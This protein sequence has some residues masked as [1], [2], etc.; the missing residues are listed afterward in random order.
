M[1]W[2]STGCHTVAG[3]PD[4]TLNSYKSGIFKDVYLYIYIYVYIYTEFLHINWYS[5]S[6][7]NHITFVF[8]IGA[9]GRSWSP[10]DA[11]CCIRLSPQFSSLDFR[12]MDPHRVFLNSVLPKYLRPRF[13][14]MDFVIQCKRLPQVMKR[15]M[16]LRLGRKGDALEG[17]KA[18][19]DP[20][21]SVP[22][23]AWDIKGR[24]LV[25]VWSDIYIKHVNCQYEWMEQK[26]SKSICS[27]KCLHWLFDNTKHLTPCG[28][29]QK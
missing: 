26:R 14:E 25:D 7:I 15:R 13:P 11:A 19:L 29:F 20:F 12:N 9:S 27:Y 23:A 17:L 24:L 5:M 3:F 16:K 6:S 21:C 28:C 18:A 8:F 1:P 2:H 4:G 22:E 10:F